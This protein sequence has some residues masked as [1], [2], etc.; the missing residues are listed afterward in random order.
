MDVSKKQSIEPTTEQASPA[1]Q[2]L[3]QQLVSAS[4]LPEAVVHQELDEIC[5]LAGQ[6]PGEL[7]LD[8]LRAAMLTYLQALESSSSDLS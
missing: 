7:T 1:G 8:Q 2:E 5:A 4:G 6:D 3:I